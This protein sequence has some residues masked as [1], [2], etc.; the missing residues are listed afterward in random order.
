MKGFV[1][2]KNNRVCIFNDCE[3][4]A[5]LMNIFKN[6]KIKTFSENE[7]EEALK[8]TGVN[9]ISGFKIEYLMESLSNLQDLKNKNK[10]GIEIT[11]LRGEKYNIMLNKAYYLQTKK[12]MYWNNEINAFRS[13]DFKDNDKELVNAFEYYIINFAMS[14]KKPI[15]QAAKIYFKVYKDLFGFFPFKSVNEDTFSQVKDNIVFRGVCDS[16]DMC[17]NTVVKTNYMPILSIKDDEVLSIE[18]IKIPR[19]IEHFVILDTINAIETV[20]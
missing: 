17:D 19:Q 3:E 5:E 18:E 1:A 8:W 14:S 6:E 9:K 2:V 12:M 11:T 4:Q 13:Y 20:F 16:F 7:K 10:C 15:S